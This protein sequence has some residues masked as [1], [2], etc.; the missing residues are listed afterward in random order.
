MVDRNIMKL[1]MQTVADALALPVSTV[2]RWIRQGRIPIQRSGNDVVFSNTALEKWAG[3]HNLS[4]S[5]DNTP[6]DRHLPETLD[7]L[8]SAM[9]RG[10]VFHRIAGVDAAAAL[11]S[12]VDAT[13]FLAPDIRDE[14]YEKLIQR[15][16]LASTGIGNGIAIP[17]PRDPLS[18]PPESPVI[19]TCFLEK[20]INF[21]AIDDLP[22][23]VYFLLI[24]PTVKHHLHLLSRLSYCIRD[25]AFVAFLNGHPDLAELVSR[26][27]AFEEQ[28]DAL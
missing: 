19:I 22:V 20:P 14:L 23:F 3:T 13:D 7:S 28:L 1:P 27:A 26:V 11:R 24:S 2:K 18:Q 10:K 16:R 17:H 9:E 5:L 25:S 15:E 21:N 4:F 6:A 12:A 8:A